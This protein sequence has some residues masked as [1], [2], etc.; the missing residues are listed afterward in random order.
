MLLLQAWLGN[1]S[2]QRV[3][4]E[5]HRGSDQHP[6]WIAEWLLLSSTTE[7]G[8]S[9]SNAVGGC[10]HCVLQHRTGIEV[11]GCLAWRKIREGFCM[12][13]EDIGSRHDCPKLLAGVERVAWGIHMLLE[14]IDPEIDRARDSW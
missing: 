14:R 5:V 13:L 6:T 3:G 4:R 7:S 2:C 11:W 12:K 10:A 1:A 8:P 9:V